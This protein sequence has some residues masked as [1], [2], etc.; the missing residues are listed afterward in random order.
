MPGPVHSPARAPKR[1]FPP[2]LFALATLLAA[3]AAPPALAEP[4]AAAPPS[5]SPT[6]LDALARDPHWLALVHQARRGLDRGARHALA[7][8]HFFF[9]PEGGTRPDLELR[10][11]LDAFSASAA[12]TSDAESDPE[13]GADRDSESSA[14]R[15]EAAECRCLARHRFMADAGL[16]PPRNTPCPDLD[17]WRDEIG[18]FQLTLVFPEAFLG[19][20]ASMF[21]HTILRLDPVDLEASSEGAALLGWAID[22]SANSEGT[23]GPIYMLRGLFGGYRARFSLDP[24]Y[25]KVRFYSDWQDR[26]IWE[27][28]LT[29]GESDREMLLLHVWELKDVTLPYY[30]FTQNCSE[31]LLD[32]LAVAWPDIGRGGGFPP[33]VT[34]VDT[35]RAIED[36]RGVL[37]RPRLRR[38]PASALQREMAPLDREEVRLIEA[39]V[40]GNIVID[41]PSVESLPET[42]LARVLEIAYDLLRHRYLAGNIDEASSRDLSRRLLL[43]RSRIPVK[44]PAAPDDPDRREPSPPDA[45]HG[46]ARI[47]LAGGIQDR[48][49]FLELHIQPAYHTLSDSPEGFAE[50]GQIKFLDTRVRYFPELDRVRLHELVLID[51]VTASPWRRPFRPLAW[52]VDVGLRT[53]LL[54]S[55]SDRGLDTEGVFRAQGG[56]G[57]AIAPAAGLLLY[58][59]GEI[60]IE[61]APGIE[62]RFAIGPVSRSGLTYSTPRGR[63]TSHLE[64]TAGLLTGPRTAPW[65][66]LDWTQ[67]VT[68]TPK[69]S[70]SFTGR[71]EHAYDVG[72]F[73]GRVGL[74]RYF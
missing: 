5:A 54:S 9:H 62:G 19:N 8:T 64:A 39:I 18:E 23:V 14:G 21:G 43:A 59:F 36:G 46:T 38:S 34:P 35:V 72:A 27:Y 16:V 29:M 67:R 71:F 47:E 52:R 63:Y 56:V 41:D 2:T 13:R 30:F 42:R 53:R 51:I 33:A 28:P 61:A 58:G 12:P 69:W 26:D 1:G 73:E 60:A 57:G 7:E 24:Y 25:Q 32:L 48:D 4:G 65:L 68:L 45:G 66:A 50:G 70:A 3:L 11:T 31:K 6:D 55:S 37:G 20:P 15:N 10:A 40:A 49:G 22:Y 44:R 74:I 17:A